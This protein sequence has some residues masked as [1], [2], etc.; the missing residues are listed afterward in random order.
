MV[1]DS[2]QT[3]SA[4]QWPSLFLHRFRIYE[5]KI[6]NHKRVP[7]GKISP[8]E[9]PHLSLRIWSSLT[10]VRNV[11]KIIPIRSNRL[12]QT[13]LSTSRCSRRKKQ[14]YCQGIDP[15]SRRISQTRRIK[16]SDCHQIARHGFWKKKKRLSFLTFIFII[17]STNLKRKA[18][19]SIR[20]SP[21][22]GLM[23]Y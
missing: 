17:L 5:R 14:T 13:C 1:S 2:L 4:V 3:N 21:F 8:N 6:Q 22:F 11:P 7:P 15:E 16:R 19:E 9:R 10:V 12:T 18:T 23:K 20:L